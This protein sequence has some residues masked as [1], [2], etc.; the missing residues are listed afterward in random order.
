MSIT[1][2]LVVGAAVAMSLTGAARAQDVVGIGVNST[3]IGTIGSTVASIV[4]KKAPFQMR[5]QTV[6]STSMYVPMVNDNQIEFGVAN[7]MQTVFSIE[8]KGVSE[9]RPNPNLRI[10]ATLFPTYYSPIVSVDSDIKTTADIRGHR[11]PSQWAQVPVGRFLMGAY[12]ANGGMIWD[13]VQNVPIAGFDQAEQA[14]LEDRTDITLAIIGDPV[15]INAQRPIRHVSLADTEKG[16]AG[17]HEWVPGSYISRVEPGE[18][19][20]GVMEPINVMTQDFILFA[21]KDVS[22]DVVYEVVKAIY[23]SADEFRKA[24]PMFELMTAD[25]LAK[26]IGQEY[27]PGAKKFYEEVGIFQ[28]E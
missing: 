26:D 25:G 9:G 24:N 23:G 15:E 11:V 8:G 6:A 12:L 21:N 16:I 3:A 2:R 7:A 4:S 1:R 20:I 19:R 14:F 18:G 22:D 5:P 10:V 17:M 13:D 27:H 28:G